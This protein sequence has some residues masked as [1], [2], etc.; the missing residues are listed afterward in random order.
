MTCTL[1]ACS[2][3][4]CGAC[5]TPPNYFLF[6]LIDAT[7]GENLLSNGSIN[8]SDIDVV[9][10][11]DLSKIEFSILEQETINFIQ[12]A[13]I[14]WQTEKV[15]ALIKDGDDNLFS[16]YVDAERKSENCCSFTEYHEIEIEP[17]EWIY[18][19]STGVYQIL[20]E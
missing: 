13:S 9:N 1:I 14:G 7:T 6:E 2:D 16:L 17:L 3:E 15:T 5:F 18:N 11:A 10:A 12:I 19:V 8:S 4:E 20:I